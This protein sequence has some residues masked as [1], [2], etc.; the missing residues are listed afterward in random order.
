M[1]GLYIHIPFCVKKC[2]YCDFV[3]YVGRE[4]EFGAYIDA[5]CRE[6]RR[7][8][9]EKIDTVFIG[10]GT[11]S[12][13]PPEFIKKLCAN[14]EYCFEVKPGAERSMEM[15]PGT[16]S[17][18]K[19]EAMLAGGINR[20]SVGVQSFDDTELRAAGRIHTAKEAEDT[21]TALDS[22]GFKNISIDLMQSLPMQTEESFGKSLRTAVSLPIRHIS[23]YSLII[24]SGTPMSVKYEKGVYAEPDEDE[25]RELYRRT[26]RFLS[27]HGFEKYEIS[28]YALPGYE[29]RHNTLYWEC[30]EYIGLG[31][32][33]HSY[34]GGARFSNT[35]SL[36][37]YIN[38]EGL[39]IGREILTERDRMSEF[40]MLGLRLVRGISF[41]DFKTRF[42]KDFF[43][44]YGNTAEKFAALGL[45]EFSNGRCRLTERGI[46]VS[47]AVMCEFIL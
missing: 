16:V 4:A 3:S 1:A 42:G 9:G 18:A 41:E 44:V 27:K 6:M 15:N 23:V 34:Y 46:D 5:L 26:G 37:E 13:L 25:E 36:R 19:I 31:A 10:G 40:M 12:V 22:A 21:V 32:A 35:R 29:S 20:A 47:N 30:G 24:E 33:A 45:L 39:G 8:E 2:E 28:N 38:G 11:P 17:E 43:S 14:I 7:Y